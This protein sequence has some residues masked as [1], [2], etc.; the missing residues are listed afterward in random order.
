MRTNR[1][2][3][4]IKP[5]FPFL[6]VGIRFSLPYK[7]KS[8]AIG[9]GDQLSGPKATLRYASERELWMRVIRDLVNIYPQAPT[10]KGIELFDRELLEKYNLESVTKLEESSHVRRYC[11]TEC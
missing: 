11:A 9:I 4:S 1:V 3:S 5:V 8:V 7:T 10:D 6:D 2:G